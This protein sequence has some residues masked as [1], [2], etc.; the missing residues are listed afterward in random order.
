MARWGLPS[1][2]RPTRFALAAVVGRV[3]QDLAVDPVP[4]FVVATTVEHPDAVSCNCDVALFSNV[5]LLI[6]FV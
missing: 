2:Q 6:D 3:F 5:L 4:G 1:G